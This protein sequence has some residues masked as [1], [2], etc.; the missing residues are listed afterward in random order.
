M[1]AHSPRL[2]W[3][4]AAAAGLNAVGLIVGLAKTGLERQPE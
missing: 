3:F 4:L 1:D 2:W